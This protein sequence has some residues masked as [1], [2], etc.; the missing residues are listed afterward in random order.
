MALII[1]IGFGIALACMLSAPQIAV[2]AV[3][4]ALAALIGGE[5]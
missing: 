1:L 3:G 2:V 4:I 5:A